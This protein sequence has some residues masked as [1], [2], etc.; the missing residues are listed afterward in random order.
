VPRFA[1]RGFATLVLAM[2]VA[3]LGGAGSALAATRPTGAWGTTSQN[4]VRKTVTLSSGRQFDIQYAQPTWRL[5]PLIVMLPGLNQSSAQLDS[6]AQADAFGRAH[7]VTIVYGQP[8]PASDGLPAWNAG[9]CCESQGTDDLTYLRDVVT[10]AEQL[11]SIDPHRVYI[12]GMSNG[13]MMA[14]QALC[15]EPDLFAAAVS[16]AGPYLGSTCARPTW[17]HLAGTADTIVPVRGGRSSVP[18]VCACLFP[19]TTTEA[20]RFRGA[21]VQLVSG[22]NHTWP[23][24]T[25]NTWRFD[26]MQRAWS[27]LQPLSLPS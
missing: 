3:V 5:A 24:A 16:V 21:Q 7:G 14:L 19:A 9:S 4:I 20:Q 11:T 27:Y 8:M 23:Q 22:A 6:A 15:A 1:G 12:V 2:I 26:G 17:L 25:D 18:S 10:T 13:G